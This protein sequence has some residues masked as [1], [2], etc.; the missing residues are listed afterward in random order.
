MITGS[1]L[2]LSFQY[3]NLKLSGRNFGAN[4]SHQNSKNPGFLK[5]TKYL[6]FLKLFNVKETQQNPKSLFDF[7]H[8]KL[9]KLHQKSKFEKQSF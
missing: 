5:L 9:H 7:S 4:W 2:K 6:I 3:Q 1:A 8:V